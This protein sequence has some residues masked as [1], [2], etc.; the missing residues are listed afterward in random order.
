MIAA[1]LVTC[2]AAGS[3][4][5]LLEPQVE[6]QLV[7]SITATD[8][9]G[10]ILSEIT[11]DNGTLLLQ[12]VIANPDG[13]LSGRYVV[14]PAKARRS[15]TSKSRRIGRCRTG[16]PRP[17]GSARRAS[18]GS[19]VGPTRR[20]RCTV[21]AASSGASARPSTWA[22]RS[23]STCCAS[24]RLVLH[25]RENDVEPY[26]GEVWSWS[27]AELNRIAYVDG[28]GD[29][30]VAAADGTRPQRLL[31]GDFTLPAWSDDGRCDCRG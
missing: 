12:G 29:L 5:L 14:V 25:E 3:T 18:V 13:S 17:A 19:R 11:W 8:L 9:E 10:G 16:T 21:S 23:T 6:K 24:G 4:P 1:L 2:A 26:D 27:P 30:W 15:L 31:K 28:K 20:C 7:L 22:A